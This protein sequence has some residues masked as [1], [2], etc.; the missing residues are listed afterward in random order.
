MSPPSP[1]TTT[2]FSRAERPFRAFSTLSRYACSVMTSL[3]SA[4]DRRYWIC[5]GA[6]VW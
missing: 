6:Y 2:T 1:S 3:L 4:S 5:S